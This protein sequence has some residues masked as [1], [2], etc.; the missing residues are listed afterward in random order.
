MKPLLFFMMIMNADLELLK[1]F[2]LGKFLLEKQA[3][4]GYWTDYVVNKGYGNAAN[5]LEDFILNRAPTALATQERYQIFKQE[6][7]SQIREGITI[8]SIPCGIMRDL[9]GFNYGNE[10][11][12]VGIDLDPE[13]LAQAKELAKEKGILS[14]CQFQQLDAWNLGI[15]EEFDLIVSNGLNIYEPD[16]EKVTLLYKQFYQALKPNG[17]LITSFLTPPAT[18]NLENVNL[19]D[20]Q[21]QKYIFSEVITAKQKWQT[22]RTK[23]MTIAQLEKAGFVIEKIIYDKAHI[24]PTVVA[25]K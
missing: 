20:A 25:R 21:K 13:S 22:F 5:E 10:Y 19:Q 9:V 16:D 15:H 6:I 8:A 12:I 24:F 18:W 1:E 11:Q 3:L 23:E 14:H 4:N 2:E 17:V 7:T